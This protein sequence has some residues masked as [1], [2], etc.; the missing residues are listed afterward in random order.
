MFATKINATKRTYFTWYKSQKRDKTR[1]YL[2]LYLRYA[3]SARCL[4]KTNVDRIHLYQ[5]NRT[6]TN[7]ECSG[8][9]F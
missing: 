8:L 5:R 7:K 9:L 4:F 3:D 6:V 1:N 2:N